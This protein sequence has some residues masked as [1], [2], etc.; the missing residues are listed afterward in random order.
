MTFFQNHS[1]FY[2]L[3][4]DFVPFVAIIAS[5]PITIP[6]VSHPRLYKQN[7]Q[8]LH[9]SQAYFFARR[10]QHE[11]FFDNLQKERDSDAGDAGIQGP[12]GMVNQKRLPSPTRLSTPIR[13]PMAPT[14]A[15]ATAS[16]SPVPE[17]SAR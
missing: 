3:L 9:V 17:E 7:I 13:P 12:D 2:K 8:C 16:P 10:D 15:L 4:V 6:V 5:A 11:L 1:G 14:Q